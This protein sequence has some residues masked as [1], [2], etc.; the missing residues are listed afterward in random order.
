MKQ[1]NWHVYHNSELLFASPDREEAID[2][3]SE[4][5]SVGLLDSSYSL[6]GVEQGASNRT[7]FELVGEEL[8]EFLQDIDVEL[9]DDEYLV[10]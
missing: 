2:L 6:V 10:W 7:V 1:I 4:Q 8:C 5:M 9:E 3:L